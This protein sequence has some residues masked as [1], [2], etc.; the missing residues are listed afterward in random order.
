[1]AEDWHYLWHFKEKHLVEEVFQ[2]GNVNITAPHSYELWK[3]AK[4]IKGKK[5][6]E[7]SKALEPRVPALGERKENSWNYSFLKTK[8]QILVTKII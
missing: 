6:L 5:T 3:K 7:S 4:L 1:M 2:G 8:R